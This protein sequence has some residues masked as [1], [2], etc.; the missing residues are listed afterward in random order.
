MDYKKSMKKH[1]SVGK[2][3]IELL[4]EKINHQRNASHMSG[5]GDSPG[6]APDV[7]VMKQRAYSSTGRTQAHFTNLNEME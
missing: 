7:S 2:R 5:G 6:A 1:L 3:R 4:Q